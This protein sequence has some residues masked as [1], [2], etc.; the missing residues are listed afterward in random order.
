MPES[1]LTLYARVELNPMPGSTLSSHQSGTL[2]MASEISW[3]FTLCQS[4]LYFPSQGLWIW[5]QNVF[6]LT[7]PVEVVV[8]AGEI[9]PHA[10]VELLHGLVP[11][12][13]V[14][15]WQ[16]PLHAHQ[17]LLHNGGFCNS[18]TPKRCLRI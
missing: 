14:E 13:R 8:H 4:R 6:M 7:H 16:P 2:D 12:H 5:P 1:T 3:C 10:D 17:V 9:G 18:C 15:P 11:A